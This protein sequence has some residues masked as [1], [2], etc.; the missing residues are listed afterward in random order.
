MIPWS[1]LLFR[2]CPLGNR[3]GQA[4]VLFSPAHPLPVFIPRTFSVLPCSQGTPLC[5]CPALRPRPDLGASLHGALMLPPPLEQ[6]RLQRCVSFGAQSHG[7]GTGCLRF[8]PSLL[9]T[10]Q[11]SLPGV[12]NLSGWDYSSPTEFLKRVSTL[13]VSPSL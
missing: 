5:S 2:S 3:N 1:I 4:R 13:W 12:A 9:T 10:T 8:V 7:F 11:D 6:R